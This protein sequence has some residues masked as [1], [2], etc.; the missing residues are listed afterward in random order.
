MQTLKPSLFSWRAALTPIASGFAPL[1][2]VILQEPQ[3]QFHG[4]RTYRVVDPQGH[5][6]GFTQKLREVSVEE[7]EAAMPGMKVWK[8]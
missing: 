7:L 3:D 1:G 4:D 8:E 5:I 6:W 2:G